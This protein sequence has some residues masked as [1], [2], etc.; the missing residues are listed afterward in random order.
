MIA[1]K[2]GVYIKQP[3]STIILRARIHNIDTF[4][5]LIIKFVSERT[6]VMNKEN[7]TKN[8]KRNR[9]DRGESPRVCG[10]SF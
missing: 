10:G 9:K 3:G 5:R 4:E 8:T 6:Q 2:K 1:L 7:T